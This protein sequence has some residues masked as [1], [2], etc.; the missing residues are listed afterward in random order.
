MQLFFILPVALL[1]VSALLMALSTALI[2]QR[3]QT[4]VITRREVNKRQLV[5]ARYM[6]DLSFL[7]TD[8]RFAPYLSNTIIYNKGDANISAD[9][10]KRVRAIITLPN[11]GRCDHTYLFHIVKGLRNRSLAEKTIFITGSCLNIP[12]KQQSLQDTLDGHLPSSALPIYETFQNFALEHWK[13]T[14]SQNASKNPETE[15]LL[16]HARPFGKWLESVFGN[17]L[18][19]G[20]VAPVYYGGIFSAD[21]A[22]LSRTPLAV[23]ENLMQQLEKHSNP[24]AGHYVER[25]WGFLATSVP[26]GPGTAHE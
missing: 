16:A 21:A 26:D 14:D 18:A 20:M 8:D 7:L 22:S 11:V 3:V 6:E 17:E 24:E 2:V 10:R 1:L 5:I 12:R 13:A 4:Y 19:H 23:Y 25:V 9:I 15:L